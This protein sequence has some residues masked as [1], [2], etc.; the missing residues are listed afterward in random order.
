VL[1]RALG[2]ADSA[3]LVALPVTVTLLILIVALTTLLAT[4]SRILSLL[5]LSVLVLLLTAL[6]A[7][8]LL[9]VLVHGSSSA[10]SLPCQSTSALA[11]VFHRTI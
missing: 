10:A 6:T 4:L 9:V 5:V 3:V 8:V 11:L 1:H 7:L 2:V